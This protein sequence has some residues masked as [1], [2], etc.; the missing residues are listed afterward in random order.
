MSLAN[1][2][3]D[4][5]TNLA[6]ALPAVYWYEGRLGPYMGHKTRTIGAI[7]TAHSAQA[8]SDQYITHSIIVQVYGPVIADP[9]N[10]TLAK[11]ANPNTIENLVDSVLTAVKTI[12]VGAGSDYWFLR[13]VR[14]DYPSDPNG[15]Q[16]RAELEFSVYD[17]STWL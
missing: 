11:L 17:N 5:K 7:S 3:L 12:A 15:Q 14:I 13:P 9:E 1:A 10:M 16:T 8:P 4:I 2:R 6:T